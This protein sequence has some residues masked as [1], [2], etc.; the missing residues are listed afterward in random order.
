MGQEP[1]YVF[2]FAVARRLGESGAWRAMPAQAAGGRGD[3]RQALVWLW[4]RLQGHPLPP[5][6]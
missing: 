1:S 5:P 2:S 6:R 3:P 4:Q